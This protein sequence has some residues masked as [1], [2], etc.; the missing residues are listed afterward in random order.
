MLMSMALIGMSFGVLSGSVGF[1]GLGLGP[2]VMA[3]VGGA[4][5][6]WR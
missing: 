2:T 3:F 5:Q 1:I 4:H 6:D